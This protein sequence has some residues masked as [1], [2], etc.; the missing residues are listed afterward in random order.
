M[1]KVHSIQARRRRA[2]CH[3]GGTPGGR[4]FS[5]PLMAFSAAWRLLSRVRAA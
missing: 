2:L 5:Y 4:R 3:T 1:V